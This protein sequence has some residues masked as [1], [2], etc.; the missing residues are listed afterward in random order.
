MKFKIIIICVMLFKIGISQNE[1][2]WDG[3]YQ[4]NLKDI[5][6][7]STQIGNTNINSVFIQN[8]MSFEFQM[9]NFEFMITK[10][11]NKK[12]KNV[13]RSDLDYILATD[14]ATAIEL[15]SF[16]RFIF[17]L[18]ELY[19]RKL[20]KKLYEEKNAFSDTKFFKPIFDEISKELSEKGMNASK[21]TN[22]GLQKE[23]LKK[24]H[25]DVLAEIQTYSNFCF[26]CKPK[27]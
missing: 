24:M 2:A 19:S 18:N 23:K 16:S 20:R 6:S 25:L 12:V 4:L 5:K 22:F 9:S 11:F 10:N 27:K 3:I 8:S 7:S 21:E 1:I 15:V 14:T 26:N 17:D 13:F